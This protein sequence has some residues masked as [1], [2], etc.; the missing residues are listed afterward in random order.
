MTKD[1]KGL[2][3][4]LYTVVIAQL[5]YELGVGHSHGMSLGIVHKGILSALLNLPWGIYTRTQY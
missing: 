2:M 3:H 1:K 5:T 4:A